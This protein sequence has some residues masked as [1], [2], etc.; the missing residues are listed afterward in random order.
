MAKPGSV[1]SVDAFMD[2]IWGYDTE[3]ESNVVW[4]YISYLRKKIASLGSDVKIK[5][6]R[7]AGYTLTIEK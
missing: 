1:V 6:I 3:T 4:V 5:A 2:H 7:N